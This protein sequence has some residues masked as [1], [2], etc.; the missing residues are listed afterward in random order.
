MKEIIK[1]PFPPLYD[2]NSKILILGSF[3]SVKSRENNFFY[4]HPHNRFWR[5][6]AAVLGEQLPSTT[7]EKRSLLLGHGVALWDAIASC[8]IS[9]SSDA[10][11]SSV[12]PNDLSLIFNE[13]D[14]QAICCNGKKAYELYLRH[15]FP[16]SKREAICLPSTSPANAS[17]SLEKLISEYSTA[18]APYLN[19]Q[20]ID[21]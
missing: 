20:D 16:T 13:A 15:F 14:I 6:M 7:E 4:G 18:L 12:T 17:W 11:I 21:I 1:H 10:S 8:E 3:P 5:V 9:G 19:P 2:G